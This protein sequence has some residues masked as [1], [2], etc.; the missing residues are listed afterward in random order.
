MNK[1]N[2]A[3]S[4][5]LVFAMALL[6]IP[7]FG[8]TA[9]AAH[10]IKSGVVVI[11]EAFVETYGTEYIIEN[12]VFSVT[13]IGDVDVSII[14]NNV[15][16]DRSADSAGTNVAD[17]YTAGQRL[18]NNGW[19]DRPNNNNNAYYV[20]TCPFLI[21][22]GA[23]VTARFD[24]NCTFKAGSNGW[25]A[26][27]NNNLQRDRRDYYCGYAGIQVD[28]GASLTISSAQNLSAYR[29]Y[30]MASID[31]N[32]VNAVKNSQTV[33]DSSGNVITVGDGVFDIQDI[34]AYN[35]KPFKSPGNYNNY[36]YL[37]GNQGY[38]APSG[39]E[40]GAT[41]G[42]GAGIGG[43]AA[44]NTKA[45][46]QSNYTAGTPGTIIINT[47]TI[48]AV[49]GHTAAGIGGGLNGAAT[50]SKIEI[51]GG[52]ITAVAGRFAAAI[53]DG[54][55]TSSGTS[56]KFDVSNDNSYE[57]IINGGVINAYGGLSASAI[58][59]TD[60]IT[61]K[62]NREDSALSI[63]ITG[64]TITAQSGESHDGGETYTAA[65]GAGN[66]TNMPDN[67]ITIYSAAKIVA[68]SFSQ[69][70]ISNYGYSKGVPSVNIDPEGY[71]YLVR[72]N[73]IADERTFKIYAIHKNA[74]GHF[75]YV[76]TE[77]SDMAD[78]TVNNATNSYYYAYDP[79]HVSSDGTR[80]GDFYLVDKDGANVIPSD[81]ADKPD[82]YR[83]DEDTKRCYPTTIPDV[84]AY[85]DVGTVIE[86]ITVPGNYKAVAIT[87]P[88][89]NE[90]GGSYV[91]EVP[92]SN[93]ADDK[94][95][96][97]L[98]KDLPGVTSGM[99]SSGESVSNTHFT[100]GENPP[101]E[102]NS[103]PNITIDGT[104][105]P[106][107]NLSVG[108]YN[109][110][111]VVQPSL[112]TDF[113]ETVYGYTIYVPNETE[114][115]WLDFSFDPKYIN[116]DK[117]NVT[118]K[119]SLL[120]VNG[121]N[122]LPNNVEDGSVKLTNLEFGKDDRVD[123]WIKK[124]D[125]ITASGSTKTISYKI[126]LIIKDRYSFLLN[127][128][129]LDK[130]YDGIPVDPVVTEMID[131]TT[132]I[133]KGTLQT[134]YTQEDTGP[135]GENGNVTLGSGY[136][137]Y[138]VNYTINSI[139]LNKDN[140]TV[141][142]TVRFTCT[143]NNTTYTYNY[144]F[145]VDKNGN[146]SF[147]NGNSVNWNLG[148][149]SNYRIVISNSGN[150]IR[151]QMQYRQSNQGEAQLLK[152]SAKISYQSASS[153][154]DLS[155]IEDQ[156]KERITAN[157]TTSESTTVYG[158]TESGTAHYE[159]SIGNVS[160]VYDVKYSS[161]GN[162]TVTV[163]Y[164]EGENQTSKLTQGD[165]DSIIYTFYQDKDLD[166]VYEKSLGTER[167]TNAGRYKIVATLDA[168]KY[169]AEGSL[170]F[171]ISQK[172]IHIVAIENWL[173][174]ITKE[175]IKNYKG[176]ILNPGQIYF[177][178]VVSG[179]TV[180]LASG[181][182]FSYVDV[183]N[184]GYANDITYNDKKIRIKDPKLDTASQVNY[185]L[186]G[187][188]DNVCYVPGQIAYSTVGAI[189]RKAAPN[190]SLWRKFYPVE[191][192]DYL[193]WITSDGAFTDSRVDYHS[194]VPN[195]ANAENDYSG[196]TV[197]IHRE[198]VKLRTTG[199]TSARYSVDIEFGAMQYQYTKRVWNVNTGE[200][201]GV[202]GESKW[203]GNNG[204]NNAVTV[205]NRSNSQIYY[206]VEF[207]IDFMYAAITEGADSGIRAALFDTNGALVVGTQ[208]GEKITSTSGESKA[209][210]LLSAEPSDPTKV[211]E[212]RSQTFLLVLSG[213]PSSI[214]EGNTLT[215]TNVGS[216]TVE[217]IELTP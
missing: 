133:E 8:I 79:G 44:Y 91:L 191:E 202:E 52:N 93:N 187:V 168:A 58:G 54:D 61:N 43:G 172:E 185:I 139:S 55:S 154:H 32:Y 149:N 2:R 67:Q 216:V 57:I 136:S 115:F 217:I 146:I 51:N 99:L 49:G 100:A 183:G 113:V 86:T 127:L 108:V 85:Y 171:K 23:S 163:S 3:L 96:A 69:Y 156:L 88:N 62:G 72:F 37:T 109:K 215:Y 120:T 205:T 125:T 159:V 75:M 151:L 40:T 31:T 101:S 180:N 105:K 124:T 68:A 150:E 189:F 29:A 200:Y 25:Y 167:P 60:E 140:G 112:I 65:I 212:A 17:I 214:T 98:E 6:L 64:G 165:K 74:N 129:A 130:V 134:T 175:E 173:K 213:V 196:G 71:V 160:D 117:Q 48:T 166:G 188:E 198:Y 199:D 143:R 131:F 11:D 137:S 59:T 90:Y 18:N 170:E 116:E 15:Q 4:L 36:T 76:P 92:L 123:I 121:V 13:V 197:G 106:F 204:T 178:G 194:P 152:L 22:G 73:S 102:A 118:A 182:E 177:E 66:G 26:T 63:T 28:S 138:I 206:K 7:T 132:S 110:E 24:G 128:E 195:G 16:I 153:S 211:G 47:G 203:T 179:E 80:I 184:D 9:S 201:E 5:L 104:A 164:N 209:Q 119:L 162:T 77:A 82:D 70:A 87:L 84:S 176:V 45:S 42:G 41:S 14:F 158:Y 144:N 147:S 186:V 107:T 46:N 50:S 19:T 148:N 20:P 94:M 111:G 27:N 97:L 95:Y 161:T 142:Y 81:Y 169:E 141:T 181:A 157:K 56:Y 193:T 12:G 210:T 1:K 207:K 78:G 145:T 34:I 30:Q 114:K 21:T 33:K 135:D 155:D 35:S 190:T 126:T 174:Y 53:G 89:P 83:Y 38:G 192:T 10:T 122:K 103:T 39:A 208:V